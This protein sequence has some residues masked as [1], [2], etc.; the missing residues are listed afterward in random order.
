MRWH[1]EKKGKIAMRRVLR[2]FL[3]SVI[4][5]VALAGV[6]AALFGIF[7]YTPAPQVAH[8]SGTLV[9]GTIEVGGLDRTY[10]IYVPKGLSKGAPLVLV[11]HGAGE[12][13]ARMRIETGYGFDRQADK[14]GFAVVY[15]NAYAGY[16]NACGIVGGG[17]ADGLE[18]DDVGF[19]TAL[20]DKLIA[21][22]GFDRA[23]VFAAGS[24]R[25]GFMAFR[26][27]L[28][29]PARFRA[30]A[31]VSANLP[32][33]E[34]FKCKPAAHGTPSVMIMNGTEDPLVPFDGGEVN[35]LGLFYRNGKVRSSRASAQYFAD[36]NLIAGPPATTET[37]VAEG[38]R[39]ERVLWHNNSKVEVELIAVHGGGH[40]MPQPYRRHPGLLGPSP[41]E[42]NGSEVIWAFFARQ[43]P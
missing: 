4:A 23:R 20:A 35:L 12:N 39:V 15:P 40:G 38:V 31:A 17:D 21:D 14:N 30:V 10:S 5:A 27:A 26:L 6:L 1:R 16:W 24:S 2:F 19:L 42:P 34:N 28:E 41:T 33:P 29:A 13:G 3:W 18:T 8:L 22:F 43:R 37:E 9:R 36:L 7:V 11:M 25:G 32:T